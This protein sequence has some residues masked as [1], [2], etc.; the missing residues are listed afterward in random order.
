MA[1]YLRFL[2]LYLVSKLPRYSV[3]CFER[4]CGRSKPLNIYCCH[5]EFGGLWWLYQRSGSQGCCTSAQMYLTR[6]NP[7]RYQTPES[8]LPS[9]SALIQFNHPIGAHLASQALQHRLPHS[10]VASQVQESSDSLIWEYISMTWW[11]RYLRA[12]IVRGIIATLIVLCTV[13]VAFTGLLSQII[14]LSTVFPRF[15]WLKGLP[16]STIAILQGVLP[17]CLLAAVMIL[18]PL[19]LYRLILQQGTHSRIVVELSM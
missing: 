18:L 4:Q 9:T 2:S 10:M 12:F 3:Y 5:A 13:P 19:I 15:S 16:E 14:Y 7:V 17:A 11:E 1:D 8:Q 6:N